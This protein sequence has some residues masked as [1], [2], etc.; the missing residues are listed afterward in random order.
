MPHAKKCTANHSD[1][2]GRPL[3]WYLSQTGNARSHCTTSTSHAKEAQHLTSPER[4]TQNTEE[5]S[6][7]QQADLSL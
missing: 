6:C 1:P 3:R 5:E 7:L 2:A 4:S